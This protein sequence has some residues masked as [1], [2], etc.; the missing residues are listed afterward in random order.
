LIDALFILEH[1]VECVYIDIHY[2]VSCNSEQW[3]HC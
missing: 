1:D 3:P 2:L